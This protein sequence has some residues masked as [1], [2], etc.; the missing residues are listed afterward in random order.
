MQISTSLR[1]AIRLKVTREKGSRKTL[2]WK[3]VPSAPDVVIPRC[4]IADQREQAIDWASSKGVDI[5]IMSFGFPGPVRSISEKLKKVANTEPPM[6]MFA[7]ASNKGVNSRRTFPACHDRVFGIHSLDG[8]GH[9]D[10]GTNPSTQYYDSDRFG[11]LGIGLPFVWNE[12]NEVKSGSSYA[13]PTVAGIA[14]N[15]IIWVEYMNRQGHIQDH[16]LEVLRS[17]N[18]IKLFLEKASEPS[19]RFHSVAPWNFWAEFPDLTLVGMLRYELGKRN[20]SFGETA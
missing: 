3:S 8:Y 11:A 10:G 20:M 18:G 14:A 12:K 5:M 9:D 19:G 17:H 16:E 4:S 7:A 2:F 6:L 1:S 13:T 15:F